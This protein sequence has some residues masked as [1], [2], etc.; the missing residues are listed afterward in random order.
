MSTTQSKHFVEKHFDVLTKQRKKI[1]FQE[2][3]SKENI[4]QKSFSVEKK[5]DETF[6]FSTNKVL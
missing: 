6:I 5:K 4:F 1:H 3:T 2:N